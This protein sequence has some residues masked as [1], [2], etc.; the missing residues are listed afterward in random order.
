MDN[1]L[2]TIREAAELCGVAKTTITR[3]RKNGEFPN[4]ELKNGIWHIPIN[5]LIAAH[6]L[7]TVRKQTSDT[8]HAEDIKALKH[9]KELAEQRAEYA[10]RSLKQAEQ[11]IQAKQDTINALQTSI[12]A[13]EQAPRTTNNQEKV[14]TEPQ[15]R[16]RNFLKRLFSSD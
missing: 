5:D 16:T 10:E 2:V 3:A 14:H 8:E 15:P 7:D 6:R 11:I 4:A 9:A 1:Q 12:K 13:L